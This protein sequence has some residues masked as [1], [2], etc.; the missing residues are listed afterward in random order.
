MTTT[1]TRRPARPAPGRPPID[2]RI[3]DRRIAVT[4]DQGRRRLRLLTG[5][6]GLTGAVLL[7]DLVLHSP[8]LGVSSFRVTG[9]V[10]EPAAAVVRAAA[11]PRHRPLFGLDTA[12]VAARVEALPWVAGAVVR[13]SWP[14]TLDIAV[15]ERVAV[16]VV[17]RP[18]RWAQVDRTGRILVLD[19]S[20]APPDGLVSV[21]PPVTPGAPGGQVPRADL[22]GLA[23]A[24]ALPPGL[25][26]GSAGAPGSAA[27]QAVTMVDGGQVDLALRGGAVA[28]LGPPDDLGAKMAALATVLAQV[29]MSGVRVVDLRVPGR[30]ALTR[31]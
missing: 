20:P 5:A 29:D 7:A 6:V 14:S 25:V 23:V 4:R 11:V 24:A 27:V 18:G 3:R 22:A 16:A 21:G 30:P 1:T 12:A 8:L 10:H 9:A 31:A 15:T 2:P 13:K 28:E 17:G 19:P 26:G